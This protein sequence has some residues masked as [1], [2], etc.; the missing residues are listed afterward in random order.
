MPS[1]GAIAAGELAAVAPGTGD[2]VTPCLQGATQ[3]GALPAPTSYAVQSTAEL[4][5]IQMCCLSRSLSRMRVYSNE[6]KSGSFQLIFVPNK[7]RISNSSKKVVMFLV[8]F[9]F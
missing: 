2:K 6:H 5:N 9:P 7:L 3:P 4:L 8:C 1:G